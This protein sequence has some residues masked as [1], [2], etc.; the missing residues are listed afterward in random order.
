MVTLYNKA[1]KEVMYCKDT[2][3]ETDEIGVTALMCQE[4]FVKAMFDN[5]VFYE[6][7]TQE[8][9]MNTMLA[10]ET[11]KY[12]K[13]T[14]DGISAYAS[15]SAE[16]RLAKLSGQITEL[17]HQYTEELLIPVRNEVLAG[18]WI[19]AKQK[20]IL[21]GETAVGASLYNRLIEQLTN[22]ITANY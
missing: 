16:F 3:E 6:G 13:R 21:I 4:T 14:Q 17:A 2:F 7:A 1:T 8:E 15:I 12:L 18:Q 5:D 9:I 19:S 10:Q 11:N 22:Y 20:L